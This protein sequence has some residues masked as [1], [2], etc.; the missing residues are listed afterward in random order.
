MEIRGFPELVGNKGRSQNFNL[1]LEL[2]VD[3]YIFPVR[4]L[5]KVTPF[6]PSNFR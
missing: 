6:L 2:N 1:K 5:I 4:V 3:L